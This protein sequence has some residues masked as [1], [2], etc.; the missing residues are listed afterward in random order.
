MIRSLIIAVVIPLIVLGSALAGDGDGGYSGAFL[1]VPIGA[2]PTAMGGAYTAVSNDGAGVRFNPS[3]LVTLK[4]LMLATSYRV[5]KLDRSLGYASLLI[6]T[7]GEAV[8][9]FGWLYA[10]SGSVV[11]RDGDGY[12]LDHEISQN[13]HEFSV[14]F[15]KR[16]EKWISLGTKLNYYH[17]TM[18]E[19]SASSIG[20][21]MGAMLYI[22][23]LIDREKRVTLPLQDMQIGLTVKHISVKFPWNSQEYNAAH[24]GDANG[25]EQK[26][27]VP[28]EIGLGVS[29]RM[30]KRQLLLAT[31]L[32]KNSKQGA[33]FHGGVEYSPRTDVAVR[34]GFS[35]GRL[36]AGAGYILQLGGQVLAIDYAFSTD[37]ADEGSEH[38][39]SFD[40][41]F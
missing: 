16:F 12:A 7:E 37:R 8:L 23:Q 13:N 33:E 30:F 11:A 2:R 5:M 9:G 3:G 31:D 28:W 6:P 32:V 17:L 24:T 36:T 21:D 25:Y 34:G 20:F 15:A 26:D 38:I 35:D 1:Q 18:P 29:T 19:I 41:L 39:F 14:V 27:E 10:G 4:N 40:L 22:D